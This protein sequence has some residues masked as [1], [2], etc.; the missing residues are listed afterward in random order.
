MSTVNNFQARIC[1]KL[2]QIK[3]SMQ[4]LKHK[5]NCIVING[6]I[7]P[8]GFNLMNEN[9][10]DDINLI[11]P[12]LMT[13]KKTVPYNILMPSVRDQVTENIMCIGSIINWLC[14]PKS[15]IW[16]SGAISDKIPL[17]Q[18]P[19]KI[20][21]VRGP[22][23]YRYLTSLGIPCPQIY[24]DPALLLPQ[25][26]QP[27]VRS[28]KFIGIIPHVTELNHPAITR[29]K[30]T[31]NIRIIN[32]RDYAGDWKNIIN[33]VN[34]CKYILSSSLHG[35]IIAAAYGVP[36]VWIQLSDHIIGGEFKYHDFFKSIG[37]DILPNKF[38]GSTFD[39]PRLEKSAAKLHKAK[40]NVS[41]LMESCPFL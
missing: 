33:E 35:L 5:D 25:Y 31:P 34:Q 18:A 23:T 17:Q 6:I 13:G 4:F 36:Y 3:Y 28:E 2:L 39:F 9:W 11:L 7:K 1:F 30:N 21:A 12:S 26:Y 24:G 38:S 16:G 22:L 20:M 37:Q 41:S 19:C 32:L 14:D 40:I 27:V 8:H 29:Y 10:G 15:I